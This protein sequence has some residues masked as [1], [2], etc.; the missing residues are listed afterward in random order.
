M[1][2]VEV[3]TKTTYIIDLPVDSFWDILEDNMPLS[4]SDKMIM[5]VLENKLGI[6]V[7]KIINVMPA[8]KTL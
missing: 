5:D 3:V 2:K 1:I 8:E 7:D 6:G 4:E